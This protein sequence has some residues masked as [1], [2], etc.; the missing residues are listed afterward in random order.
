MTG[1][2]R[3]AGNRMLSNLAITYGQDR[4]ARYNSYHAAPHFAAEVGEAVCR[5]WLKSVAPP[6]TGLDLPAC[7]VLRVDVLVLRVPHLPHQT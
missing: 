2:K 7:A 1:R 3:E 5:T 4:L 6:A